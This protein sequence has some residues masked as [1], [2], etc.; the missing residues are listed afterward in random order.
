MG[1]DDDEATVF[2]LVSLSSISSIS[3][4]KDDD[5]D[6]AVFLFSIPVCLV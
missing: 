3:T 5:D 4:V 2:G 1:R 6:G